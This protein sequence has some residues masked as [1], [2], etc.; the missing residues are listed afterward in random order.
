MSCSNLIL[1]DL[2]LLFV[3]RCPKPEGRA[4]YSISERSYNMFSPVQI[5]QEYTGVEDANQSGNN[6]IPSNSD[7]PVFTNQDVDYMC[8]QQLQFWGQA[9]LHQNPIPIDLPAKGDS[10]AR[11]DLSQMGQ[12]MPQL[13][14]SSY[15]QQHSMPFQ[16][17]AHPQE[18]SNETQTTQQNQSNITQQAQ[19]SQLSQISQ[20]QPSINQSLLGIP[21]TSPVKHNGPGRPPKASGGTGSLKKLKCQCEVCFKE[22]GHKSNLF[23]HMRTHNGERPYKCSQCEKCFTHSGNLAIHMRTHSGERPYA[24]QICGK[25]FSHSGNLSTHLRTH[26][27]VKPYKCSYCAKEFRHSGNLSIHERI[28]SGIKPFQCKV[29]GKQFYHSGNLTTH[30]KK[31]PGILNA[32]SEQCENSSDIIVSSVRIVNNSNS[33]KSECNDEASLDDPSVLRSPPS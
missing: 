14:V 12:T 20:Q 7:Y 22:F 27:G 5:K 9:Q 24:C 25:M 13:A 4:K 17:S 6:G 29:C 1:Y 33:V 23:I 28:H 31:H 19:Q 10:L 15:L 30:M 8:R 21:S 11:Q 3:L 32:N 2:A 16:V 26:S 18:A